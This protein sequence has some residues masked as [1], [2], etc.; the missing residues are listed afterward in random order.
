MS[1]ITDTRPNANNNQSNEDSTNAEA[2]APLV[3]VAI[4]A[5]DPGAWFEEMLN[6]VALQDYP[7]FEVIVLDAQ[8]QQPLSERVHAILPQAAVVPLSDNKGYAANVNVILEQADLGTFLLLCHD[9]VALAPDALTH[10]VGEA[11]ATNAGIVGPKLLDWDDPKR[12]LHVG[13][14]ADKTGLVS[15]LAEPGEYDQEQHDG[16]KDVF[17]IPGGVTLVRRD[18]FQALEGYD[19]KMTVQG[20][21]LDLCWRAHTLGARVIVSPAATARHRE[22]IK[23]RLPGHD[24]NKFARRHRIRAMLSNYGIAHSI[25]V[26]PQAM[27]IA[28]INI[29]VG[30]LQGRIGL[31]GEV[32]GAWAW[33]LKHLGSTMKRRSKLRKIRQVPDSEVRALQIAGFEGWHAWRR[34]RADRK[35]IDEAELSAATALEIRTQRR[36]WNMVTAL[37]TS[38]FLIG[39]LVGSRTLISNGLP[40]I[41]EFVAFP[42]GP[43]P[44]INEWLTTWRSTGVGSESPS[45]LLHLILGLLG[46]IFLGQMG[47]LQLALT[48]GMI[49]IGG[50]GIYR[51]L[52]P[53]DSRLAQLVAAFFYVVLPVAYNALASGS[54]SGLVAFG[55]APWLMRKLA[56]AAGLAP[57]CR[58][59]ETLLTRFADMV[60]AAV[61]AALAALVVPAFIFFIPITALGWLLGALATRRI[62]G[63]GYLI[64]ISVLTFACALVMTM[65]QSLEIFTAADPWALIAGTGPNETTVKLSD[66]FKLAVGPHAKSLFGWV[67]LILPVLA[68]F[69]TSGRR[70][71]WTASSWAVTLITIALIWVANRGYLPGGVADVHVGLALAAASLALTAGMTAAALQRDLTTLRFGWSHALPILSTIALLMS[72]AGAVGA[73]IDGTWAS[74]KD[75]Y[76]SVLGFMNTRAPAHARALWIGQADV[77]PAQG[78]RYDD[79]LSFAIT[80][81]RLP[82]IL[83]RAVGDPGPIVQQIRDDMA[84]TLQGSS[85]RLGEQLAPYGI[86][87]ILVVEADAPAPFGTTQRPVPAELVSRLDEQLDFARI[88]SR[89]GVRIYE[90]RAFIPV[91]ASIADIDFDTQTAPSATNFQGVNLALPEVTSLRKYQGDIEAGTLYFSVLHT[92]NWRIDQEGSPLP[93]KN[94]DWA[95][96]YTSTTAGNAILEHRNETPLFVA[97][98][99]QFGGWVL[100]GVILFLLRRKP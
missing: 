92:T 13:L 25:A 39:L 80:H 9:D 84:D 12:L 76:E 81:A 65:P 98:V 82:N 34:K 1:P 15:D 57:F 48:I 51:L 3:T 68:I 70:L 7:T 86:R 95:Q 74:P 23:T 59:K 10:L 72:S 38:A 77:V 94:F 66:L 79:E 31:V 73:T 11:L 32:L 4:V 97:S 88:E 56:F 28:L 41:N 16:V 90:N 87:Y 67:S 64:V 36:R 62:K 89:R 35:L 8:S 58:D 29:I 54:W 24:S 20:E 43:V 2:T 37:L 6:S 30:I 52:D 60:G 33:N 47:A 40:L 26:I 45:S 46:I 49:I 53:F 91:V 27:L 75:G 78:W 44:L 100:I 71:A 63:V 5:H 55:A 93:K 17:S 61:V 50:F 18:L 21:D 83:D 19:E 22:G 96:T 85:S 14:G 69:V 42:D 99:A